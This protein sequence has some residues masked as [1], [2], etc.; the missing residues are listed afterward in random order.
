M[1]AAV[2]IGTNTVRLLVGQV[3]FGRVVPSLYRQVLTRLGGG[4]QPDKGLSPAARERTLVALS[5]FKTVLDRCSPQWVRVVGTEAL[6]RAVNASEFLNQVQERTGFRLE[7]ITGAEEATLTAAGVLSVLDPLPDHILI[8]DI[9][10]GSSEFIRVEMGVPTFRASYPIGVVSLAEMAN[11][12]SFQATIAD[13]IQRLQRELTTA[14]AGSS[15]DRKLV[16]VG[17][18]GTITTLA[19]MRLKLQTYDR[20][21]INNLSL[22]SGW[23]ADMLTRLESLPLS[24]REELPGMEPGR[25]DLI[26]PGGRLVLALMQA[27]G[28]HRVVV[29]DA[30][31]LEGVLL[32]RS[33]AGG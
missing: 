6:R 27:F 14:R 17:T 23:L 24:A 12:V 30:G 19:A 10:G 20:K 1:L 25:G 15:L 7:V 11:G 4:M 5:D 29:S 31:L 2:D 8:F 33:S 22:E 32:A 21:K 28:T 9:G 26:V 16:L 13:G 3:R 18:A